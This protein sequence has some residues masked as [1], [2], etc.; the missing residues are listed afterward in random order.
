VLSVLGAASLAV[1]IWLQS[2]SSVDFAATH[3]AEG[4]SVWVSV[5][6]LAPT[7]PLFQPFPAQPAYTS[8]IVFDGDLGYRVR[9]VCSAKTSKPV[10]CSASGRLVPSYLPRQ[11][12]R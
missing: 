11:S 2:Q 5:R 1:F 4:S 12:P 10:N 3:Y 9:V 7:P 6:P 8:A